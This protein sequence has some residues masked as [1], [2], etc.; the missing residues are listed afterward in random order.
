MLNQNHIEN[1]KLARRYYKVVFFVPT[2]A[3]V[4][5]QRRQ[6]ETY[7]H[8]DFKIL[9]ISGEINVQLPLSELIPKQDIIVMT[10]Q[11]IENSLRVG[12]L[13][14]LSVLTLIIFD[15][16]HH[17]GKGHPYNLIMSHYLDEMFDKKDPSLPQ[18]RAIIYCGSSPDS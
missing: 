5:Q 17:T 1:A 16:C 4:E 12:E 15:E 11:I 6:F 14:S 3:L 10:P 2:V 7:L 18:V 8:P 9:G 13:P